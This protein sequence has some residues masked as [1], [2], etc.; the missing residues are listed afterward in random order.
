M[1]RVVGALARAGWSYGRIAWW[2]IVS[3]RVSEK[4]SLVV[5]QAVILDERGILLSVRSDLLGWELPGGTLEEGESH[6][7]A[8]LREVEEETGLEVAVERF[9]GTYERT[10]FRPHTAQV[11]VCRV[12][13]GA[14]ETSWESLALRWF[15]PEDLPETLFPWY[16]E[17]I[18]DA[19]AETPEPV[20]RRDHQ[21]PGEILAGMRIDLRMR[22]SGEFDAGR[23]P[24]R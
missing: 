13:G 11:Y 19:L 3:P 16:R 23:K 21:G 14:L 18:A 22:L 1:L 24:K 9:V 10:G 20:T 15:A 12:E 17:P 2:G 5:L 4:R 6:E 7:Q 8:L